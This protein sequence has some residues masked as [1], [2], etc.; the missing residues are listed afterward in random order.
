MK[1]NID[2]TIVTC[3]TAGHTLPALTLLEYLISKDNKVLLIIDHNS[4][5]RY[6]HR[7][8]TYDKNKF[9]L[10]YTKPFKINWIFPYTFFCLICKVFLPLLQTKNTVFCFVSGLQIPTVFT[11]ILLKKKI[12]LHEQDSILNRTNKI[13]QRYVSCI[14]SS[15]KNL[16]G[17]Q[18]NK[19]LL[20]TGCLN[21]MAKKNQDTKKQKIITILSGTNGSSIFD[22]LI[23]S[24]LNNIAK[25]NKELENYLIFHNSRKENIGQLKSFYNTTQLNVTVSNYFSNF[26][27]L[28]IN[29]SFLI[30]RAGASTLSYISLYEKNTIVIPWKDSSQNHQILNALNIQNVNGA[31]IVEEK[32]IETQLEEKILYLMENYNKIN[33]GENISQVFKNISPEDYIIKCFAK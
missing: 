18:N 11:G 16:K 2:Y 14:T 9:S 1:K 5:K 21:N 20:W 19:K 8:S 12:I 7:F 33:L 24:I 29:S 28:I 17:V 23:P 6:Q 10:I 4:G 15:F 13:F 32:D 27:D 25:K 3:G 26:E 30:T 22:E 31:I